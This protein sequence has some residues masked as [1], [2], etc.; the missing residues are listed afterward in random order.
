MNSEEILIQFIETLKNDKSLESMKVDHESFINFLN[1]LIKT[2][3]FS[4]E[5]L[6]NLIEEVSNDS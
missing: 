2:S 6:Q 4:E 3:E 1:E 5:T